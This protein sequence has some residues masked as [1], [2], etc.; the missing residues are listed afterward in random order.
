MP[1]ISTLAVASS[2]HAPEQTPFI[3]NRGLLSVWFD[4]LSSQAPLRS[5]GAAALEK[6]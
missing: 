6:T 3:L 1:L 4:V 2:K 5:E